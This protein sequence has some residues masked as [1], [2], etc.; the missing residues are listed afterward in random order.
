M[1]RTLLLSLLFLVIG[2]NANAQTDPNQLLEALALNMSKIENFQV[3]AKIN[4]DVDFIKIKERI[5]RI[6]YVKP[7]QF[8]FDTDGLALLPKSGMQMEYLGLINQEYTA[9]Q[10]GEEDIDGIHTIIIKVIPEQEIE[11]IILAQMWIDP[12]LLTVMRMKTYTKKS[13]SYVID[14]KFARHPFNLPD[15]LIVTF[16]I[17]NMSIPAKMMSE[18]RP[19]E[20]KI[21]E[22]PSEAKVVVQYSNYRVN[23]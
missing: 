1:K 11:D 5:V 15:Q 2:I 19:L 10:A 13:G 22:G 21:K 8:T 17:S 4:V 9:I 23:Q 18:F 12:K 7:D 6:K 14:F 16:D 20:G 3:D